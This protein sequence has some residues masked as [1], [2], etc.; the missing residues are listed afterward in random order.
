MWLRNSF[1]IA[2]ILI[3]KIVIRGKNGLLSFKCKKSVN[4][5]I[6]IIDILYYY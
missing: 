1:K 2:I 6:V 3:K 5:F 4:I